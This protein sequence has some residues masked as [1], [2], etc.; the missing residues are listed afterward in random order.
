MN[1]NV[2]GNQDKV[3]RLNAE[4]KGRHIHLLELMSTSDFCHFVLFFKRSLSYR[5]LAGSGFWIKVKT[6][7]FIEIQKNKLNLNSGNPKIM[8]THS[9]LYMQVSFSLNAWQ[10]TGKIPYEACN[11]KR[12]KRQEKRKKVKY[13]IKVNRKKNH[14]FFFFCHKS[15]IQKLLSRTAEGKF[16]PRSARLIYLFSFSF[17]FS[18]QVA[19]G[20]LAK[21]SFKWK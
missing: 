17:L 3:C 13:A 18:L 14:F 1:S 12:K 16:C 6:S 5:Y 4:Q 9:P 11:E 20:N 21:E 15:V 7:C 10:G 2:I 8:K 19:I